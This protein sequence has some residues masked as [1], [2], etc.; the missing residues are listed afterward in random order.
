MRLTLL[1]RS[2]DKNVFTKKSLIV[3]KATALEKGLDVLKMMRICGDK[4]DQN[5]HTQHLCLK[6]NQFV[7]PNCEWQFLLA[8]QTTKG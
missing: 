8:S 5:V 2:D 4:I 1:R 6:T 7:Q 3:A